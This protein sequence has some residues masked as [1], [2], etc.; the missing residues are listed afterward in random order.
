MEQRLAL[1]TGA[2]R[3]IGRAI[4][5][6]LAADGFRILVNYRQNAEGALATCQ[7]IQ[8]RGG[9]AVP[10]PFDITHPQQV[11]E[12]V[13]RFTEEFGII[14]VLVNNAAI[15]GD[16]PL[17]RVKTEQ[18]ER[19][20]SANLTGAFHCTQ[21]VLKT[22]SKHH[23]GSRIINITSVIGERG[24]RFSSVYSA[25]KAGLIGFT[26]SLAEEL[27][28]KGVTVNAVSP[29]FIQT[30]AA[31]EMQLERFIPHIPLGRAGRPEEVAYL[32]AF[33]ASERAAYITGQVLRINGGIYM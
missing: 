3:G 17:L 5:R 25:S 30:E 7:E 18:W 10:C 23:Y 24:L 27:G 19:T 32:V 6:Q 20:L 29:G 11:T 15:P 26:K 21:A 31:A 2:A 4:A 33:L 12:Q 13:N 9:F 16:N 28:P 14:D 22:W 8:A 1:I